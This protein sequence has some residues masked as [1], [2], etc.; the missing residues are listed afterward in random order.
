MQRNKFTLIIC[1]LLLLAFTAC[2]QSDN[3]TKQT[4]NI[5]TNISS[6]ESQ[7]ATSGKAPPAD[8]V[9]AEA[10]NVEIKAG[11][12]GEA[13]VKLTVASGYHINA[14]PPSFPYLK[15][16]ELTVDA[17]EGV[18]AGKPVYPAGVSR[19]FAF[20][21]EGPLSVYEG[22]TAI[23]LPLTAAGNAKKGAQT[24]K[25]HLRIQAC[26]EEACFPPRTIETP[27]PVTVN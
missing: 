15:A 23:K 18:T 27:I 8:V 6:T 20:S 13:S 24:L 9:R 5:S 14:N 25:G 11:G 22:E 2:S 3:A 4:A 17:G 1:F 26:N 16:T 10:S 7:S 19:Q 21:K 12:S